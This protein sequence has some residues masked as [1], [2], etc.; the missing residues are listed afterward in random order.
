MVLFL[1]Y[2]RAVTS[3]H[4]DHPTTTTPLL[5]SNIKLFDS[6]FIFF[7]D[8]LMMGNKLLELEPNSFFFSLSSKSVG[9]CVCVNNSWP[10]SVRF[11]I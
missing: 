11:F 1:T 8:Y 2:T 7:V 10:L 4:S 6:F 9:V 3:K 5:L